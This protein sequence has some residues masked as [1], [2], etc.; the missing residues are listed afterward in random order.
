MSSTEPEARTPRFRAAWRIIG[1]KRNFYRSQWEANYA[2]YLEWLKAHSQIADWHH[3]PKTFWF[4]GIKRGVCSYKPDFLVIERNG[5]EAYHEVKG[6][7]DSRSR[8][9]LKRMAKYFPEIRMILVDA[10]AYASIKR[11]AAKFIHGWE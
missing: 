11:S 8:T 4:E 5:A 7:M 1:G 6:Q 9:T 3:E 2:R 10:K